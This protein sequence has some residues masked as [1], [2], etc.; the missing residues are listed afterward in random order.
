MPSRLLVWWPPGLNPTDRLLAGHFADDRPV[1]L[2]DLGALL[3]RLREIGMEMSLVC[4]ARRLVARLCKAFNRLGPFSSCTA[5][6]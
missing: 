4:R 3:L 1:D 5:G 6:R 2:A